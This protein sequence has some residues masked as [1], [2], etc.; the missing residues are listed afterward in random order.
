MEFGLL[1]T[2]WRAFHMMIERNLVNITKTIYAAMGFHN[3]VINMRIIE[4]NDYF[5]H[6]KPIRPLRVPARNSG[7]N[8]VANLMGYISSDIGVVEDCHLLRDFIVE[9]LT[10]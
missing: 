3:Y 5:V 1:T 6:V 7:V 4:A 2:K 8:E 10:A 9:Q